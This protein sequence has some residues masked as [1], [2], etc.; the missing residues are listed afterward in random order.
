LAELRQLQA[1]LHEMQT[2]KSRVD[3]HIRIL[4]EYNEI[5]DVAQALL[6]RLAEIE[7]VC[8]RELYERFGLDPVND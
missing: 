8:N 3:H 7:G 5:K 1:T 4:H 6:G 2:R